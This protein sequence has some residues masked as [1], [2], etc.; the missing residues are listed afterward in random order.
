MGLRRITGRLSEAVDFGP[1]VPVAM[2]WAE[3]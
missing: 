3:P 2:N 1:E